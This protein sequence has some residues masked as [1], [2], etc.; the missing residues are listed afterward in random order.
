[1][2]DR[3]DYKEL[4]KF[5]DTWAQAKGYEDWYDYRDHCES[6]GFS[7][8]EVGYDQL[9]LEYGKSMFQKGQLFNGEDTGNGIFASHIQNN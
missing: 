1:M 4:R 2:M 3:T 5:K 8:D 7:E 6:H 9:M